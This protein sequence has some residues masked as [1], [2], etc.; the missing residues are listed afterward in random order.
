MRR[1]LVGAAVTVFAL[2]AGGGAAAG[3]LSTKHRC[4]RR[5]HHRCPRV[6][7]TKPRPKPKA[8]APQPITPVWPS[9]TGVDEGEYFLNPT[10]TTVAAGNVELDP[11]NLGMDEHNLTIEDAQGNLVGLVTVEPGQTQT[12]YVKLVPGSYRLF[13]SLLDHS[14]LGMNSTLTV[15]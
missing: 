13:C 1:A 14:A 6:A 10:H 3:P 7:K 9:R 8:K 4:H 11:V 12:I 5:A 2:A 15:R